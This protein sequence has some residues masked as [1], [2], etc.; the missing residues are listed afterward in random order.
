VQRVKITDFGLARLTDD[1]SLTQSGVIAGTPMF[2]APEQAAG[3]AVDHRADLFSLGSVLYT[4]CTGR[5]PFRASGTMAVMKRVIEENPTP[6]REINPEIPEWLSDIIGKLQAKK[7][8]ERFQT[9]REVAELLGQHLAHLQQPGHA[10]SPLAGTS[11][12]A[13]EALRSPS[14]P[15]RDAAGASQPQPRPLVEPR[16]WKIGDR[17]FAPWEEEWSYAARVQ[18]IKG[19]SVHVWFDDG[20]VVWVKAE[21][22][23]PLDIGPGSRVLGAWDQGWIYYPGAV[24]QRDGDRIH[25]KYDDGDEEWT[26]LQY[27]CVP[28]GKAPVEPAKREYSPQEKALRT[29]RIPAHGLIVTGILYWLTIPAL[30]VIRFAGPF[31]F[32]PFAKMP[33][34]NDETFSFLWIRLGIVPAIAGFLLIFAG[35]KMRHGEFYWLCVLG[36]CLPIALLLEKLITLQ[37]NRFAVALGDWTA[38]PFGTW[39]LIVLTRRDVRAAFAGPTPDEPR[40]R[41]AARGTSTVLAIIVG[42]LLTGLLAALVIYHWQSDKLNS[43]WPTDVGLGV[44]AYVS[45]GLFLYW[46]F[47]RRGEQA[48]KPM[49]ARLAPPTPVSPRAHQRALLGATAIF[50][51]LAA[52]IW[53]LIFL[54][55]RQ[56]PGIGQPPAMKF[57]IAGEWESNWG[58][59]TLEHAPIADKSTVAVGGYYL[60]EGDKKAVITKGTYD[61]GKG[62]LEFTSSEPWID[63]TAT[64]DLRLSS[65]GNKLEGTWSNSAG[66]SGVWTMTRKSSVA[67]PAQ[68]PKNESELPKLPDLQRLVALQEKNV[69]LVKAR[70][71][72][73]ALAPDDLTVAEIEL[74]EAKIRL[75]QADKKA[76]AVKELGKQLIQR[77]E[78]HVGWVKSLHELGRLPADEVNKSERQLVEIRLRFPDSTARVNGESGIRLI[79]RFT[80]ADAVFTRDD[81]TVETDHWKIVPASSLVAGD[82]PWRLFEVSNPGV[83]G[84]ILYYRLKMKSENLTTDANMPVLFYRSSETKGQDQFTQSFS[85]I[86][87]SRDWAWYEAIAFLKPGESPDRVRL[88]LN[89]NGSGTLRFKDVELYHIPDAALGKPWPALLQ[90]AELPRKFPASEK[91]LV[92]SGASLKPVVQDKDAWCIE[93]TSNLPSG[94]WSFPLHQIAFPKVAGRHFLWRTKMKSEKLA[95]GIAYLEVR[96]RYLQRDGKRETVTLQPEDY[97][98]GTTDW[99]TYEVRAPIRPGHHPDLIQFNLLMSGHG[100]IWIKDIE[101]VE[102]GEVG[103]GAAKVK[104]PPWLQAPI[105]EE[106]SDGTI[107]QIGYWR[108]DMQEREWQIHYPRPYRKPPNLQVDRFSQGFMD[109]KVKDETAAGF[110]IRLNSASYKTGDF[111]TIRWT[112]I[113]EPARPKQ[114]P[115]EQTG[116]ID[117]DGVGDFRVNYPRAYDHPPNLRLK[118]HDGISEFAF[119]QQTATGFK[120]LVSGTMHAPGRTARIE[121]RALGLLP[122]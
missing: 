86:R 120:L 122:D 112:A 40:R 81:L 79:K 95:G 83:A 104:E 30:F 51:M 98:R 54:G 13:A 113:G 68:Q 82:R 69:E 44:L 41:A 106:A 88:V 85:F 89:V 72:A 48:G 29:L 37:E 92:Q 87:D 32:E 11:V 111:S 20:E 93:T 12:V 118:V 15:S 63:V 77:H 45:F 116:F 28:S 52:G 70:V 121:W 31:E 5:P 4:M 91:L 119:T 109:Y 94:Q 35:W 66:E 42:G 53:L 23:R 46:L 105:H 16:I 110:T 67:A 8:A 14:A 108:F 56:V 10:P 90:P 26:V 38:L 2:M 107:T 1:V 102:A 80:T 101:L 18:E 74:L 17:V 99:Y 64:A 43:A 39:A 114:A 6:I 47:Q 27:I 97:L 73:G 22:L 65:D 115:T 57:G 96:Q 117:L 84:G 19:D 100:K 61:P 25:I 78:D 59:V 55:Q 49:P 71:E 21:D 7:P 76:D 34:M 75:A 58:P 60:A 3:E 33:P 103:A 24:S 9:A 50:A 36:A 62:R